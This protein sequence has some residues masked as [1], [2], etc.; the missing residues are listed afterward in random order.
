MTG[1]PG[2]LASAAVRNRAARRRRVRHRHITGMSARTPGVCR[3]GV[4]AA[5]VMR[6]RA[7]S[8]TKP[9]RSEPEDRYGG[10]Q[11]RRLLV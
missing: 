7:V 1:L 6:W 10:P 8:G 5:G 4:K 2:N 9:S 11:A 3:R